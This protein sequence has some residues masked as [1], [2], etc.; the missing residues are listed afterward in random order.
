[1]FRIFDTLSFTLERIWLHRILVIWVLVGIS[2]ATTLSL[3][4]SLYVDSVY[5]ELLKS[6]LDDPPYAFRFRYLGAWDGNIEFQDVESASTAIQSNF[7]DTIGLTVLNDVRFTSGGMWSVRLPE[8]PLGTFRIG[9]LEN[10]DDQIIISDGQWPPDPVAAGDPVPVLIPDAMFYRMGLQIGDEFTA[11]RSGGDPL[12]VEIAAIWRPVNAADPSWIFPPKFFDEIFLVQ[13]DTFGVLLE[14]V[15]RPIDEVAWFLNFDGSNV[16]TSDVD[17]LLGNIVNGE[18]DVLSVLPDISADITPEEELEAFNTEVQQLTQ[19]LFIIIAP[20]GGLV[21]YFVALV[22]GL[23][24]N[25]Q[26]AEDVKLRSRGM[27]RHTLL[28]I[29]VLMWLLLTGAAL[30]IGII[31]SPY[32][33]RLVGQTSSFLRFDDPSSTQSIVI[34]PQAVLLGAVTG[35]VA[36]SSGLFLAWKTTRQ[37]INTFR[38]SNVRAAKV[39][40][41][42]AYLDIMLLFVALYVLF[43]LEQGGGLVAEADAAFSNPLT[44]IGPTLFALGM[45]L[46]FLRIWPAFVGFWAAILSFSRN[47]S[48]LM[49]LRELTRSADRY[50][51]A[52]LMMAF[53]LSLTGFTASM[54]STLDRS[55]EDTIDYG[56]GAD[57][58][59]ITAIDTETE[60]EQS[61]TG[62]VT[63]TVTGYNVPPVSELLVIDGVENASRVGRYTGR[64]I[65]GNRPIEGTI[66]GV[67]RAAMADVT[68]FRDDYADETLAELLNKLAGQ[69]TGILVS[70]QTA[71]EYNIII[72]QQVTIGVQ[73]LNTWYEMRVPVIGFIDYFPT[74]DPREKFFV[75]TNIDPIFEMVGTPLPHDVWLSLSPDADPE[76]VRQ[77]IFESDFPMIRASEPLAELQAARA[78]P[79]RRGVLGFLS[80]GFVASITLTLIAAIIQSTASFRA[81]ST[82]LGALRAMGMRGTSVAVYVIVL[83]GLSALSGIMSGT[84]IGV[85]TTLLFLPLLDFSGGLPPYMVRVAWDNIFLVYTAFAGVLLTVT[86]ITTL[87]LSRQQASNIVRLGET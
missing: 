42:R 70:R 23:L 83:Q 76:V 46:L 17:V 39:W 24:V 82:Q 11:Q 20:V 54:A 50:Q 60:E 40:W 45:A 66:V 47:I 6:R 64:M 15:E 32:I 34:T 2:V 74:L 21:L 41:Q 55:L 28:T 31:A 25:R 61:A 59:V 73:A 51:G 84:T 71:E 80:V 7:V 69:R 48:L 44:F 36:A 29:H 5:S 57:M 16:R 33:V 3:S 86:L 68:L 75:I 52:L 53:T 30:V 65:V 58:V 10:A 19:Q 78:E 37:N 38:Q 12:T 56:V 72:N 26:Q 9:I 77:Q 35:L 67:D 14:G 81:Q 22:A 18:R 8:M 62:E 13:P 4:L 79:A 85:V 27:S 1:M 87:F 43:D 63:S 49:A